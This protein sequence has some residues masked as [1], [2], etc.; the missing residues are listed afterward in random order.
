MYE[1]ISLIAYIYFIFNLIYIIKILI[2]LFLDF[3]FNYILPFI[4]N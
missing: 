1:I 3:N 2:F 4:F